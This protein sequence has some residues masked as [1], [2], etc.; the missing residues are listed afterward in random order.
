M[1]I[2]V[3]VEGVLKVVEETKTYG[4]KGFKKRRIVIEDHSG[5]FTQSYGVDLTGDAIE[6]GDE[7]NVGDEVSAKC[8]LGGRSWQK[9]EDAEVKYFLDLDCMEVNVTTVGIEPPDGD[10][11]PF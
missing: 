3:T 2:R 11:E 8:F 4:A 6:I 9:D 10:D 5:R 7:L 1:S